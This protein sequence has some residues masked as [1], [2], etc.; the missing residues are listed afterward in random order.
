MNKF[1]TLCLV[2]LIAA[3]C[4]SKKFSPG[5]ADEDVTPDAVEDSEA[6]ASE[7]APEEAECYEDADCDDSDSCTSDVCASGVC[8]NTETCECRVDADCD[9]WDRCTTNECM[10]DGTCFTT[11]NPDIMIEVVEESPTPTITSSDRQVLLVLR[12]TSMMDA[13]VMVREITWNV[14]ADCSGDGDMVTNDDGTYHDN[15]GHCNDSYYQYEGLWDDRFGE[16]LL[17]NLLVRDADT[18]TTVQGPVH[19]NCD[20]V[21]DTVSIRL[22]DQFPLYPDTPRVV[23]LMADVSTISDLRAN[24]MVESLLIRDHEDLCIAAPEMLEGLTRVHE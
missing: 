15:D 2:S 5:D 22:W 23:E 6:D 4:S 19:A 12:F 18:L 16:D 3:S 7:D 1:A 13:M 14:G 20:W 24:M 8:E 9:D 21:D 10:P 11:P 17:T